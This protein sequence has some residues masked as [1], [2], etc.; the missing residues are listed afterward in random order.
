M[1]GERA[2]MMLAKLAASIRLMRAVTTPSLL[3]ALILLAVSSGSHAQVVA[4]APA[5]TAA[6]QRNDISPVDRVVV[7]YFHRTLRCETCL[8]FE[9]YSEEALR[10]AFPEEMAD[11]RLVWSVLN[12]DDEANARYEDEYGLT[13]LSL[14]LAVERRGREVEWRNLPDIWGF[15]GDKQAFLDY[16]EYEV[17]KSLKEL[18]APAAVS[19]APAISAT[20]AAPDTGE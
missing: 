12:L 9:A 16:V 11:G 2:E 14:V 15:V 20:S 4:T 8:S 17:G 3:A 10:T 6:A 18:S 7:R 5:D 13:E 19:A 1:T